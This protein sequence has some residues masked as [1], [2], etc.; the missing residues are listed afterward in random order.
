M[1][2][3]FQKYTQQVCRM[4]NNW[5]TTSSDELTKMGH[6]LFGH[7]YK[8]T[9]AQDTVP[10]MHE[11]CYFIINTDTK[12]EKGTHWLGVVKVKN[13]YTIF[14]S[15]GRHSNRLVPIFI[16]GVQ[17]QHSHVEDN[18]YDVVEAINA[19]D[20]GQRSLSYLMI[21]D[22]YGIEKARQI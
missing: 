7:K 12:R 13:T 20:C 3:I 19:D 15:F 14:D 5:G 22:K 16:R 11:D 21:V 2:E 18:D 4:M 9:Y 6:H 17:A 8:G 1:E 10:H